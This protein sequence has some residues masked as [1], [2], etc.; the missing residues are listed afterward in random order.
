MSGIEENTVDFGEVARNLPK[1]QLSLRRENARRRLG[2]GD[3]VG[4]DG[5]H[6]ASVSVGRR[7][8]AD[9]GVRP[10]VMVKRRGDPVIL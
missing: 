7:R 8:A 6:G 3:G 9:R 4:R 2:R 10:I 1:R 5:R